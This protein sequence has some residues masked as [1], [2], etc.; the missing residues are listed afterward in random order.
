[1]MTAP[2]WWPVAPVMRRTL[3]ICKLVNIMLL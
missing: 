3:D 1:L 2:P